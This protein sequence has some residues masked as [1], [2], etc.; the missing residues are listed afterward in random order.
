M[1]AT[2]HGRYLRD[3]RLRIPAIARPV[4]AG[5]AA[6]PRHRLAGNPRKPGH[7]AG[8]ERQRRRLRD[9]RPADKILRPEDTEPSPQQLTARRCM[10]QRRG[11]LLQPCALRDRHRDPADLTRS[12]I[13]LV[14]RPA[15]TRR[16]TH[17]V[18]A[19]PRDTARLATVINL[20]PRSPGYPETPDRTDPLPPHIRSRTKATRLAVKTHVRS[21][22]AE[23]PDAPAPCCL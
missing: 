12:A 13:N 21:G 17:A 22:S 10:R 11:A 16:R 20:R 3:H 2:R 1:A 23:A 19:Q 9:Q 4:A 18:V 6:R 8:N 7:T 15:H 14:P 5:R